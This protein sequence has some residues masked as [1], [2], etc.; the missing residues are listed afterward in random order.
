MLEKWSTVIE[1]FVNHIWV[2]KNSKTFWVYNTP[3]VTTHEE[4][5]VFMLQTFLD[6]KALRKVRA[7]FMNPKSHF[8]REIHWKCLIVI[9]LLHCLYRKT[10]CWLRTW[11][12][13]RAYLVL[14]EMIGF[15]CYNFSTQC[16]ATPGHRWLI[17][18]C[19]SCKLCCL[20]SG[21]SRLSP[22]YRPNRLWSLRRYKSRIFGA[23][24]WLRE[25]IFDSLISISVFCITQDGWN[26][27][28]LE[29]LYLEELRI[30]TFS[31]L[32]SHGTL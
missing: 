23:Y 26:G 29:L 21:R 32:V 30:L 18:T 8:S 22:S 19:F 10:Y 3:H 13:M 14:D 4:S 11:R 31:S 5:K 24:F 6:R 2:L 16:N 12:T 20:L 7:W 17:G 1:L 28:L 9:L 27:K 15:K 25:N